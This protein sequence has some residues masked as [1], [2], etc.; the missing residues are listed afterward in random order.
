MDGADEEAEVHLLVE[1][2]GIL[3]DDGEDRLEHKS[4]GEDGIADVAHLRE[5]GRFYGPDESGKRVGRD[6][7]YDADPGTLY[8]VPGED[9]H[10]ETEEYSGESNSVKHQ[11]A[12]PKVAV[13]FSVEDELYETHHA[14]VEEV[15]QNKHHSVACKDLRNAHTT[16]YT[17]GVGS[18]HLLQ[19]Q[20]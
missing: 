4:V 2:G 10:E 13:G 9:D 6:R 15:E 3:P 12:Q 11:V 8:E 7:S 16:D 19:T 20:R 5:H 17:P 1:D 18:G 14:N